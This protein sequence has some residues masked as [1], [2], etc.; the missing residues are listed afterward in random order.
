[1]EL[2]PFKVADHLIPSPSKNGVSGL[3]HRAKSVASVSEDAVSGPQTQGSAA[4]SVVF[5][6]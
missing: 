5:F 2:A 4:R 6:W 3:V 1:M